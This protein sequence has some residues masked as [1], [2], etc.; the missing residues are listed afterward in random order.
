MYLSVTVTHRTLVTLY[1]IGES[2]G[3]AM[4]MR[5]TGLSVSSRTTTADPEYGHS[6]L[7]YSSAT[8]MAGMTDHSDVHVL[9]QSNVVSV[10]KGTNDKCHDSSAR[11]ADGDIC[12]SYMPRPIQGCMPPTTYTVVLM[13]F[14]VWHSWNMTYQLCRS[15]YCPLR[16]G[17]RYVEC[18]PATKLLSELLTLPDV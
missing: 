17:R 12:M 6:T 8:S 9:Q 4:L 3:T 14:S 10:G 13:V 5:S 7:D 18:V 2:E 15:G 11:T 16:C 1:T